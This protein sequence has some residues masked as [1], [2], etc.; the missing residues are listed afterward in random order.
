MKKGMPFFLEIGHY[1]NK[2]YV[3]MQRFQKCQ[4]SFVTKCTQKVNAEKLFVHPKNG[5]IFKSTFYVQF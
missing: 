4:H 3:I 1:R 5:P 2:K